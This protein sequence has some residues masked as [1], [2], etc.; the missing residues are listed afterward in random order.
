MGGDSEIK[1]VVKKHDETLV[2]YGKEKQML[3][4][5]QKKIKKL[6]ANGECIK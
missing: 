4:H 6:E 1:W 3:Y 2:L 5:E